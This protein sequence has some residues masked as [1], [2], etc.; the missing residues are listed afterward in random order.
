MQF[1]R[2]SL[3]RQFIFGIM[4]ALLIF[5]VISTSIKINQVD[6]QSTDALNLEVSR[7]LNQLEH[8]IDNLLYSRNNQLDAIF[9][10][11]DTIDAIEAIQVRGEP[12]DQHP[13][14]VK[15]TDYFRQ[16]MKLDPALVN[17]FF[18]TT[19]TWEYYDQQRKNDDPDYYINQR[20]FWQEFQSQMNHYVNDPYRDND[21]KFLMTFRAPLF[22]ANEK[23]IGT[24]GLDLDLQDVNK[25][26]GALQS[27]FA[28]LEVFIV[29]DSGLMVSFPDMEQQ[30]LAKGVDELKTSEI[31]SIYSQFNTKG[32]DQLWQQFKNKG[33]M[34]HL[35][36]WQGEPHRVFMRKFDKAAPE[37]HWS[38][39]V[40][41]PQQAINAAVNEEIMDS[42]WHILI[43]TGALGLFVWRYTRWQ[44]KPLSEVQDAMVDISQGNAD[45][46]QRINNSR[47]DEIGQLA[48]AFNIFVQKI[49][50]LVSNSS[51]IANEI[52]SEASKALTSTH[53]TKSLIEQQKNQLDSVS[54]ASTQMDES[55][56]YMSARAD[57]I[58]NIASTTLDGVA[59]G[60]NRIQLAS[61]QMADMADKTAQTTDVI[62]QLD[63]EIVNIGEVVEVIRSIAEQTNLLALNAAIEAARAG[64]QGRGFAVVADE[65]RNLASRT[66]ESTAHIHQI[67]EKLQSRAKVAVQA[68]TRSQSEAKQ[69][70][71]YTLETVPVF[72]DIL[73]A[74]NN[75]EQEMVEI[76]ANITQQSTTTAQ[77]NQWIVKIDSF[78]SKTVDK[79]I[80]L[81]H[82][83]KSTE[84]KSQTLLGKFEQFKF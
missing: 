82:R 32:F 76:S 55:A 14:L 33:Q 78:A 19:A 21:G 70:T 67:V 68:M 52:N 39:A 40:M 22:N 24:V 29:S 41:L 61:E 23:L 42:L 16:L 3:I 62:H 15:V 84:E 25:E 31:D 6:S 9:A 65:V 5:S 63:N 79:S 30:M 44:L 51:Q 7:M 17:I 48:Q 43:F 59:S 57:N 47:T 1:I 54:S 11:P 53:E 50:T 12:F 81:S 34:E 74:M 58:S 66:Q 35:L 75:L 73:T 18:T 60:V 71:N 4:M 27:S 10:H 20:P 83:S 72:E 46:T 38:I 69:C 28:G 8:K 80:D 2:S 37:V 36:D 26:L 13:Q 45:L 77:M 49:Q 64:E 56:K